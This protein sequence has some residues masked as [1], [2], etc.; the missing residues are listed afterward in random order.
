MAAAALRP[1]ELSEAELKTAISGATQWQWK[2]G[3]DVFLK[4][5]PADRYIISVKSKIIWCGITAG[6]GGGSRYSVYLIDNHGQV[7]EFESNE[8]KYQRDKINVYSPP[9]DPIF[10]TPLS[11]EEIA[12]IKDMPLYDTPF[13]RK[14]RGHIARI[15]GR[16][17]G[18]GGGGGGGGGK[19]PPSAP[20]EE[21]QTSGG[22]AA[23]EEQYPNS[24]D[25][26]APKT[27][28]RRRQK[29]TR[30]RLAKRR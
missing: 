9:P 13:A 12:M 20:S 22:A 23:A 17:A 4:D 30:K 11:A 16:G 15:C 19:P 5:F 1:G 10:E 21:S 8:N 27:G 29:K 26:V 6:G 25:P 14:F 7:H 2:L 3:T 18:G 28:G 24:E